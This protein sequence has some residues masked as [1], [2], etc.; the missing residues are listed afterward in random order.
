MK[1][2][3]HFRRIIYIA[4]QMHRPFLFCCIAV[5]SFSASAKIPAHA[6]RDSTQHQ[7]ETRNHFYLGI[8]PTQ[9]L[10]GDVELYARY[11]MHGRHSIFIA[12]G[13]DFNALDIRHTHLD[14]QDQ[15]R[16]ESI[17]QENDELERYFWGHGPAFRFG[18]EV[19]LGQHLPKGIFLSA[20]FLMKYRD[21]ENYQF[22]DHQTLH[23]ESA[24]QKISGLSFR[25]GYE[26]Q[27]NWICLKQFIGM[28]FRVLDSHI[29]W[30]VI[31]EGP[32]VASKSETF[33]K[34]HVVPSFH[35]GLLIYFKLTK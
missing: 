35:L 2:V 9:I 5:I 29:T 16:A 17:E 25:F 4:K 7:D 6:L 20:E 24:D 19:K 12:G 33:Y 1:A 18:Y 15:G 30:P 13:Y 14:P 31:M 26:W 27:K 28:G 10:V 23:S 34:T 21:Y 32:S 22:C 8:N 3:F 11:E